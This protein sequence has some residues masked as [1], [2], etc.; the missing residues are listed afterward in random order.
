MA[1]RPLWAIS[2]ARRARRRACCA[3]AAPRAAQNLAAS[4]S[5]IPGGVCWGLEVLVPTAVESRTL[6]RVCVSWSAS[7]L[8]KGLFR[9]NA[10][11][12]SK[13]AGFPAPEQRVAEGIHRMARGVLS[14][15]SL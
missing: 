4:R 9:S 13:C 8:H 1:A 10:V 15:T 12:L 14:G 3:C 2:R 5:I 11:L 7:Q 6:F